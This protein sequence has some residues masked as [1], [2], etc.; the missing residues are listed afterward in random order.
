MAIATHHRERDIVTNTR[1]RGGEQVLGGRFE[2]LQHF[3][4]LKPLDIRNI[5]DDGRPGQSI[6]QSFT[7]QVL[8]PVLR[9]AATAS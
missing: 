9:D 8:T 1:G 4:V 7:S 5:D 6:G 3:G 2:E